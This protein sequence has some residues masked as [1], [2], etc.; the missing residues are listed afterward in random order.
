MSKNFVKGVVLVVIELRSLINSEDEVNVMEDEVREDVDVENM[1]PKVLD[2]GAVELVVRD[3]VPWNAVP[4]SIPF[5][6]D[7]SIIVFFGSVV[8][9]VGT[10]ISVR[11]LLLGFDVGNVEVEGLG[12]ELEAKVL[13]EM[14]DA[15]MLV[16]PVVGSSGGTAPF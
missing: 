16:A 8:V 14:E 10:A 2:D 6:N 1:E 5:A 9:T 3:G 7:P 15:D 12:I 13:V 4:R 11:A